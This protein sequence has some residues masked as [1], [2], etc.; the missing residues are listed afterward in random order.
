MVIV[1]REVHP[2]NAAEP[3]VAS[4]LEK[5]TDFKEVQFW[6]APQWIFT[7]V[8]GMRID[9]NEEQFSKV[10]IGMSVICPG[11]STETRE[12]QPLNKLPYMQCMEWGREMFVKAVHFSKTPKPSP[13]T[14]LG[15]SMF[16]SEV[17]L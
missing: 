6:K 11:R 8:L 1:S 15:I 2:S 10:D 13:V 7:T 4:F 5:S 9:A 16:S 14:L 17:Q 3:M 12:E